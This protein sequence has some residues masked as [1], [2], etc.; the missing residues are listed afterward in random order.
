MA[1]GEIEKGGICSVVI[2]SCKKN[3]L[4]L[5][6]WDVQIDLFSSFSFW[7]LEKESVSFHPHP[8]FPPRPFHWKSAVIVSI[9]RFKDHTLIYS[10]EALSDQLFLCLGSSL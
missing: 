4:H 2:I 3:L 7:N 10:I 5:T 6:E 9:A 1:K 8:T